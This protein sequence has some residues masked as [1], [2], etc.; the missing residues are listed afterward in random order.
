MKIGFKCCGGMNV[1]QLMF[2]VAH[3]FGRVEYQICI[4][5]CFLKAS[6]IEKTKTNIGNSTRPNR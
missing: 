4:C 1:T 6:A 5:C 2:L 3:R